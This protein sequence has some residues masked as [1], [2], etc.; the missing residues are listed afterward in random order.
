MITIPVFVFLIA[1]LLYLFIFLLFSL[2]NVYHIVSTGTFTGVAFVVTAIP[3]AGCIAVLV[4]TYYML[5][6]INWYS[7]LI[8]LGP[9]G[10]VLFQ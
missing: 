4:T 9:G 3:T 8:L 5:V 7:N 1:Y 10:F 2:A 6:D